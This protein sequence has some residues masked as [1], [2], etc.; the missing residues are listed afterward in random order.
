VQHFAAGG[1]ALGSAGVVVPGF[2]DGTFALAAT[3][4][5]LLVA[6][7]SNPGTSMVNVV[8][9]SVDG[10]PLG[11]PVVLDRDVGSGSEVSLAWLGDRAVAV[12]SRHAASG[13]MQLVAAP[14]DDAGQ[15]HGAAVP[16]VSE[17]GFLSPHVV[18]T[19]GGALA[20][21]IGTDPAHLVAVP[22]TVH[23]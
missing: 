20:L 19:P 6:W 7:L 14:L 22:F 12:W 2:H 23:P 10:S 9:V 15:P 11:A 8:A 1:F 13:A 17:R 21:A 18:A 3:P 5:G 16:L 4:R